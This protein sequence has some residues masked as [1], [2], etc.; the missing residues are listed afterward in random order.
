[1]RARQHLW[2]AAEQVLDQLR[3]H[4]MSTRIYSLTA[5]HKTW[6]GIVAMLCVCPIL[7]GTRPHIHVVVA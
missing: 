1:M 7:K 3:S 2:Y 5:H 4:K 6:A